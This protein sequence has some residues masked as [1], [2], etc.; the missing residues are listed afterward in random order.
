MNEMIHKYP[1][2]LRWIHAGLAVFGIAAYLTGE[3]AEEAEHG[4]TAGYW[5]HAY[6]GLTLAV[7][8]FG[9]IGYGLLARDWSVAR[10]WNGKSRLISAIVEDIQGLLCLRLPDRPDHNGLAG[11]VQLFGLLVFLWMSLTGGILFYTGGPEVSGFAHAVGEAHEVGES[12]IP[13]F[14]I[15]HIGAVILHTLAGHAILRRMNPFNKQI[16]TD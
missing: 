5:L 14:L 10:W 9:R 11:A 15:L 16:T 12:L 1:R 13:L 4:L 8:L 7:F 3:L 2:S 6:L